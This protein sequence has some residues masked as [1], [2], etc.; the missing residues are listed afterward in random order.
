MLSNLKGLRNDM[1]SKNLAIC[2]LRFKYKSRK[3]FILVERFVGNIHKKNNKA[4]GTS[5]SLPNDINTDEK[6]KTK[7]LNYTNTY[8]VDG[9]ILY[10]NTY[11]SA[12]KSGDSITTITGKTV[13]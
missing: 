6:D 2:C 9:S 8:T 10:D 13:Q 5:A 1:E 12:T 11:Y 7:T 4:S 3:Y